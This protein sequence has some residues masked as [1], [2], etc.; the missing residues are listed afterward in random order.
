MDRRPH[1]HDGRFD[2]AAVDC[3]ADRLRGPALAGAVHHRGVR[4]VRVRT[5]RCGVRHPVP[6]GAGDRRRRRRA[7]GIHLRLAGSANAWHQ[8]GNCH[9]GTRHHHRADAVPQP[10]IHRR[11]AG[12]AGRQPRAVR[13]RHRLH[14]LPGALRHV[15]AGNGAAGGVGGVERASWAQRAAPAR[16]SNQRAGRYGAR[17]RRAQGEAVRILAELRNSGAGRD[18]AGIPADLGQLYLVHQ[19]HLDPVRGSGHR[20]GCRSPARCV[21][22][23]HH[24]HRSLQ[25][26]SARI[27]VGRGGSLDPT[28]QRHRHLA[29]GPRVQGRCRRRVGEDLQA[30][31][32]SPQVGPLVLH[33]AGRRLRAECRWERAVEGS[34]SRAEHREHDRALRGRR[35]GQRCQLQPHAGHHH[36]ADRPERRRQD[37]A[38]RRRVRLHA[39][40]GSSGVRRRGHLAHG[41][42][43]ACPH[44]HRSFVPD[45]RVVRRRDGVREH[46]RCCGPSRH[47]VVRARSGGAV[48]P[49][50]PARGRAGDHRVPARRRPAPRREGPV[51]RQAPPAGDCA[52][53]CDAPER[54]AA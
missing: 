45:A 13:P 29:D 24:G 39:G 33:R 17:H 22:G 31:E 36:G 44:W 25:P 49:A 53:G 7:A 38:D 11:R 12:H 9:V 8:P 15:R 51:L 32:A 3:A 27:D 28:H 10:S 5:P 48:E 2:R 52:G 6:A 47:A 18:R 43:Q 41:A 37:V 40:G 42:L 4:R 14:S 20:G 26:G 19:P 35:S 1:R 54:A 16:H 23:C 34:G 50:V 46:Q 21:R 30:G